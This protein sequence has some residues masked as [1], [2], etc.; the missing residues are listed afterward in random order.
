M[1]EGRALQKHKA[2]E[3]SQRLFYGIFSLTLWVSFMLSGFFI[4]VEKSGTA[5]VTGLVGLVILIVF[6]QPRVREWVVGR[7]LP[8]VNLIVFLAMLILVGFSEIR[9]LLTSPTDSPTGAFALAYSAGYL[10]LAGF[11]LGE[12]IRLLRKPPKPDSY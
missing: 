10:L 2:I 5:L 12:V 6:L 1:M 4:L 3:M 11:I 8:Q 9:S 7:K